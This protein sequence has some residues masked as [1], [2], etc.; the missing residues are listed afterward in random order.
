MIIDVALYQRILDELEELD[1]IRAYDE[2][3][4]EKDEVVPLSDALREIEDE[5]P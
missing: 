1:T 5:R 3:K 2:A 4:A